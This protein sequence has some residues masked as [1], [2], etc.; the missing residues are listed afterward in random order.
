MN[1][2]E[3]K[4]EDF[5]DGLWSE[6]I[7][8]FESISGGSLMSNIDKQDSMQEEDVTYQTRSPPNEVGE[9]TIENIGLLISNN[10]SQQRKFNTKHRPDKPKE[11]FSFQ[12]QDYSEGSSFE[13]EDKKEED[14]SILI[15][16]KEAPLYK[17]SAIF[18]L[19]NRS[20]VQSDQHQK[21]VSE[22][23]IEDGNAICSKCSNI[24]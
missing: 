20:Y 21:N 1:H 14:E 13:E 23:R 9:F 18:K 11:T 24:K 15:T 5:S 8:E 3:I 19:S 17:S 22:V 7:K 2:L 10:D 6:P 16:T 4:F 12:E